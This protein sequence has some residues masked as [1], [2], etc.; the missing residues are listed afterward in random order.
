MQKFLVLFFIISSVLFVGCLEEP[1]VFFDGQSKIEI[2]AVWENPERGDI[3]P[4][5][6]AKVIVSSEYGINVY[7]TDGAGLLVLNNLP[8]ATY[9]ISVRKQL[10]LDSTIIICGTINNIRLS[11]NSS[12]VDTIRTN[13]TSFSGITINEIYSSGPVNNIFFMFDQFIELYNSSDS[14]KYLDGMIITRMSKGNVLYGS[15]PGSDY[16]NDGD[17]DSVTYIFKF[18]GNPG[19]FNYPFKSHSFVVIASDAVNHTKTVSTSIDLSNVAWEMYN[20]FSVGDLDN[21]NVPNLLNMR[22]DVMV[23]FLMNLSDDIIILS[24]GRD[25]KWEDGLNIDGIID[26]VEYQ[27]S[28]NSSKTLDSRIDRSFVVSPPRYSGKSIQRRYVG[29]DTN[30]GNM[31]WEIIAHPTPGY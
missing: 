19:E 29:S 13:A 22:S 2:T 18:P 28:T 24:D 6:F 14:T 17:I 26:G 20:Q 25:S 4:L 31:D 11:F 15:G 27:A 1:P 16:G 8:A 5:S 30:D 10:P 23:D 21:P 7:S 9:N 3:E 12:F